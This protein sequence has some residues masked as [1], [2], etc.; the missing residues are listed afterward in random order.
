MNTFSHK[1]A[2]FNTSGCLSPEAMDKYAN[3]KLTSE[4]LVLLNKHIAGCPFCK[5]ALEGA[6]HLS[7][8]AVQS[9]KINERLRSRFRYIPARGKPRGTVLSGF[10][11]PVAAS[12]IVLVGIF[13]WFQYYYPEKQELAV[14]LDTIPVQA[15][16][17][18]FRK[19]AETEILSEVPE[20]S[21]AI[22]GVFADEEDIPDAPPPPET[23]TPVTIVVVE[24]DVAAEEA[25]VEETY[26]EETEVME[27]EKEIV[28]MEEKAGAGYRDMDNTAPKK[29]LAASR[30]KESQDVAFNVVEQMPEFPGG[31]DSLQ[32]FLFRNLSYP[33]SVEQKIDTTVI[34]SF[35]VSKKGKIKDINI[36]RSAGKAFDDEVIRVIR[37]MPSWIPAEQRGKPISVKFNLPIRFEA[38]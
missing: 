18:E 24:D 12:V 23:E 33:T 25:K 3:K 9:Q 19:K 37:L 21:T 20:E 29:S 26:V 10:L 11:I 8:F 31:M 22:G 27:G 30:Q 5:D 32:S 1:N 28:E 6:Q 36:V 2:L 13:A 34:A 15:E 38:D 17:A 4:E 16:E 14:V 35:I 7:D